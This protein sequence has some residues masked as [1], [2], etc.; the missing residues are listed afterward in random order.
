MARS[1]RRMSLNVLPIHSPS[2]FYYS[3]TN[4]N[5]LDEKIITKK[6]KKTLSKLDVGYESEDENN[7]SD[8]LQP[9]YQLKKSQSDYSH[10][11]KSFE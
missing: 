10:W 7:H 3:L 2:T 11:T 6:Q 1:K 9:I 4:I 8:I 5:D